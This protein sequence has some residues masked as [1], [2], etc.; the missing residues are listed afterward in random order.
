MRLDW[1]KE[2]ASQQFFRLVFLPG[3]INPADFFTKIL[4]IYRHIAALPFFHG[5]PYPTPFTPNPPS[6]HT[7]PPRSFQSPRCSPRQGPTRLS[8]PLTSP[9]FVFNPP[10]TPCLRASRLTCLCPALLLSPPSSRGN[11]ALALAHPGPTAGCFFFLA[12]CVLHY[13]CLCSCLT[14]PFRSFLPSRRS[15][16]FKFLKTILAVLPSTGSSLRISACLPLHCL[17]PCMH[18]RC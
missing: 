13:S 10:C 7:T 12:S 11:N 16:A 3:L 8:H 4:P 1:L 5:T 15:P 14:S 18:V 2:R 17:Q 6:H 9:H